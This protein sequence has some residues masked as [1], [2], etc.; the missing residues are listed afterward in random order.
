MIGLWL[1]LEG[2]KRPL[3]PAQ[4]MVWRQCMFPLFWAYRFLRL[5]PA[6]NTPA[7]VLT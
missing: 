3:P 4:E 1:L 5:L 7:P 6:T 2:V